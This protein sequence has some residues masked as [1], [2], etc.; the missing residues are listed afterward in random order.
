MPR[1]ADVAIFVLCRFALAA[2]AVGLMSYEECMHHEQTVVDVA[3]LAETEGKSTLMA[4]LY[5]EMIRSA[6]L[7]DTVSGCLVV[8]HCACRQHWEDRTSKRASFKVAEEVGCIQDP[9]L[10]KARALCDK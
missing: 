8:L 5:D 6:S 10:R 9:V 2:A 7:R 3:A 1:D 4:V